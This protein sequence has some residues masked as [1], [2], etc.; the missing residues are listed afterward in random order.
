MATNT[1]LSIIFRR[2]GKRA[3]IT[4]PELKTII[5]YKAWRF[6]KRSNNYRVEVERIE[7]YI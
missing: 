3:T 4:C 1:G 7:R 6:N 2:K 5:H